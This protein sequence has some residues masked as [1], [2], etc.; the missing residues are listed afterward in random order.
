MFER[1]GM[2]SAYPCVY[3]VNSAVSS[4]NDSVIRVSDCYQEENC[5]NTF[6]FLPFTILLLSALNSTAAYCGETE[7]KSEKTP[8]SQ[9]RKLPFFLSRAATAAKRKA[10]TEVAR[11]ER[12]KRRLFTSE[13]DK[14]NIPTSAEP[15]ILRQR[16]RE[17]QNN[18]EMVS[19]NCGDLLFYRHLFGG[20]LK[21]KNKQ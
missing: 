3:H 15:R 8:T 18:D 1:A 16:S 12:C 13:T 14:E 4:R 10:Q 21:K 6:T 7:E 20:C 9:Q 17:T 2:K 11:A 5:K 19:I